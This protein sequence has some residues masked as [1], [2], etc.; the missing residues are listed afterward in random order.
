MKAFQLLPSLVFLSHQLIKKKKMKYIIESAF[1]VKNQSEQG[2][3]F[4]NSEQDIL[5]IQ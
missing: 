3:L 4:F 5:D 2:I 1:L